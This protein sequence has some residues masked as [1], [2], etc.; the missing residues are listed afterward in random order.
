MLS[1]LLA[2]ELGEHHIRSNV[3]S[4]AMVLTPLTAG[5]YADP[6]VMHRRQEIVP[7]HRIGEPRDIAEAGVIPGERPLR[8]YQRPRH[9]GGWRAEPGLVEPY[10]P[11]RV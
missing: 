3:V 8:L 7:A 2:V 9:L 5:I 4:P 11:A 6:A 1:Q 10:S